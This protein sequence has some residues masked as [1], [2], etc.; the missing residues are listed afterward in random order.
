MSQ[1]LLKEEEI[2]T[3]VDIIDG[4]CYTTQIQIVKTELDDTV[5]VEKSCTCNECNK[6]FATKKEIAHHLTKTHNNLYSTPKNC[7]PTEFQKNHQTSI[8]NGMKYQCKVSDKCLSST[9]NLNYHRAVHSE[10]RPFACSICDKTYKRNN[11]LTDHERV[12]TGEKP[13]HRR[14]HTGV[15]PYKCNICEK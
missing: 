3:E 9:S 8:Q 6:S 10:E 7:L 14:V 2:K 11:E 1:I 4:W 15:T 12:H 13:S 5:N